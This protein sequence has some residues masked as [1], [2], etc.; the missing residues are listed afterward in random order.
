VIR[1]VSIHVSNEQPLLCDLFDLPT[2]ADAGLL[3]TNVRSTDGRRPVF[4]DASASTFF[5]PYHVIRFIEI[6]EGALAGYRSGGRHDD[7]INVAG[8]GPAGSVDGD[9]E[10]ASGDSLLPIAVGASGEADGEGLDDDLEIDEDFLQ[11]IRDI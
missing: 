10:R 2:S 3:C 11:R 7:S 8:A 4:I 5:F 1:N 9:D 6:P